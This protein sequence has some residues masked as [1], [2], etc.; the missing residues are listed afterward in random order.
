MDRARDTFYDLCW[1]PEAVGIRLETG[2]EWS[3]EVPIDWG[4]PAIRI[5]RLYITAPYVC[6]CGQILSAVYDYCK[7]CGWTPVGSPKEF[8][9]TEVF[10]WTQ[11]STELAKFLD[12]ETAKQLVVVRGE[13]STELVTFG[14]V[15]RRLMRSEVKH[16]EEYVGG[17]V[18]E[19]EKR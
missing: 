5:G 19:K 15:S 3:S 9:A 4:H 18:P 8:T 12:N 16:R 11:S 2:P 17:R 1:L 7:P 13:S 6:S 14:E 10:Y